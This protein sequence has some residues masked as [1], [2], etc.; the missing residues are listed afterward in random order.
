MIHIPFVVYHPDGAMAGEQVDSLVQP[1]DVFPT[2]CELAGLD[3]PNGVQGKTFADVLLG[4]TV[5]HREFAI[6]GRN[7]N[8]SWG[9][10][11]ATITDGTWTL[12]YWPNKDLKYKGPKPI[13]TERY[14]CR[15]M[16]ERRVD[17][18]VL[19]AG[20]FRSGEQCDCRASRRS[21]AV[22][23]GAFGTDCGYRDRSGDCENLPARAGGSVSVRFL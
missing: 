3:V 17:E 4:K 15:N 1:V 8:D 5:K 19:Y 2:L 14:D 13:R 23:Q 18:F 9:T 11:P 6:S 10:V 22:A 7:L 20:G 16:P 21:K 12:V